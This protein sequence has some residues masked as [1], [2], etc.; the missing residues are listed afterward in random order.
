MTEPLMT[1]RDL[2]QRWQCCLSNLEKMR[3]L[4]TG[5]RYIKIGG[6]VRYRPEDV[7]AYEHTK[8]MQNTS[9][10]AGGLLP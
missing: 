5:P 10:Q 4:G 9:R 1:T 2:A 3:H 7:Y 8:T 6:A